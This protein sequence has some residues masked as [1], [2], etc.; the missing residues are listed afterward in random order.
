MPEGLKV[1]YA[2]APPAHQVRENDKKKD[3]QTINLNKKEPPA[4]S[5]A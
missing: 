1:R 5:W 2:R 3:T 4:F